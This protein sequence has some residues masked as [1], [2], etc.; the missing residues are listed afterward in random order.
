MKLLRGPPWS[1][2]VLLTNYKKAV[3]M[4]DYLMPPL[5]AT[6]RT[7][8]SWPAQRAEA[9]TVV[10][11]QGRRFSLGSDVRT[12][13]AFFPCIT[14]VFNTIRRSLGLR[15][16]PTTPLDASVHA[17]VDTYARFKACESD[18][19]KAVV[20]KFLF[21]FKQIELSASE[22]GALHRKFHQELDDSLAKS[23]ANVLHDKCAQVPK[24]DFA[25]AICDAYQSICNSVMDKLLA[26]PHI[27]P[28][29]YADTLKAPLND[30]VVGLKSALAAP[31]N[32]VA[33]TSVSASTPAPEALVAANPVP[34]AETT[35][36]GHLSVEDC[37]K[38]DGLNFIV[39]LSS[40]GEIN[41]FFC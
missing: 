18:L 7:A 6:Q 23:F 31:M 11:Y 24:P 14:A 41:G 38:F 22:T 13:H 36:E 5:P 32:P 2:H 29:G 21:L 15:R 4:R 10:D 33:S 34:V 30:V 25:D 35:A 8:S 27:Y 20:D 16:A 17:N 28:K 26:A 40:Q 39:G 9:P 1:A 3:P 19:R 12:T 37:R